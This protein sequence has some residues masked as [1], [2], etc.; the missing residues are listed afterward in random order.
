M[1]WA[2]D[3]SY[4]TLE[5]HQEHRSNSGTMSGAQ[6]GARKCV[7]AGLNASAVK[8]HSASVMNNFEQPVRSMTHVSDTF[9][10]VTQSSDMWQQQASADKGNPRPCYPKPLSVP[11]K[12]S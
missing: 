8:A 3:S 11:N 5:G 2:D 12:V 6:F 7:K 4:I 10:S 9:T 1:S